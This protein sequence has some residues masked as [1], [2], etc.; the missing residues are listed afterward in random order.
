MLIYCKDHLHNFIKQTQITPHYVWLEVD[1]GIFVNMEENLKICA[2]YNPP[3]NSPYCNKDIFEEISEHM[4]TWANSNSAIL[5]VGDLNART[6]ELS[7]HE[8]IDKLDNTPILSREKIP[9]KRSNCDKKDNKMGRKLLHLCK[10]HNLQLLNG[11][12]TGDHGGAL[13][14]F[15]NREGASSIDVLIA[16]D[17]PLPSVKSCCTQTGRTFLTLQN[18]A[19]SRP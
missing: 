17:P 10:S 5:I 6:A 9:S 7:D 16:S 11:R 18:T 3:D 13:S 8:E 4:L 12:A 19:K 15:D 2:V 1:K 14:F